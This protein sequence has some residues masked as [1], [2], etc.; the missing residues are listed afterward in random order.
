MLKTAMLLTLIACGWAGD[1]TAQ[2]TTA[3][4]YPRD[5]ITRE[6]IRDR[7]PEVMTAYDVIQRLRPHFLRERSPGAITTPFDKNGDRNQAATKVPIQV[8]INGV[9][10][11]IAAVS[12]REVLAEAV[13]DIVYLNA[14]DATTR[15]G[16]GHDN[17]AIMVA[18]GK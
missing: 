13:I 18:T 1:G 3:K 15:F 17:G 14:S 10:A 8:Y 2:E 11:G 16:T 5:L 6:E 7:A 9:K 12:L 4:K